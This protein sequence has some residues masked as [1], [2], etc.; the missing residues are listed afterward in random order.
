[1]AR[2]ID[3]VLVTDG[4]ALAKWQGGVVARLLASPSRRLVGWRHLGRG[5]QPG[6]RS[7]L[8]APMPGAELPAGLPAPEQLPSIE[9]APRAMS[10]RALVILDLTAAGLAPDAAGDADVWS[11]RFGEDQARDPLG[12]AIRDTARGAGATPVWL[13]AEGPQ[14]SRRILHQGTVPTGAGAPGRLVDGMLHEAIGWPALVDRSPV[15]KAEASAPE[16][17]PAPRTPPTGLLDR[18]PTAVLRASIGVRRLLAARDRLTRHDDWAIGLVDEPIDAFLEP[19]PTRSVRWLPRR[20]GTYAADPFGVV[21]D[22]SLHVFFEEFDQAHGQGRIAHLVV[23]SDGATSTPELVLDPGCHASYPFILEADGEVWMIPE[24]ADTGEVRL[25]RADPFPSRWILEA[26]LLQG[27]PVSDPTIVRHEDRWW[28]FGTSRGR[29]VDH[30]LRAWHAPELLGPWRGHALD[31]VKIDVRSARPAGTPFVVEG[32]LHRP[33]QD[34]SRR[35][36]GRLVINRID[37]LTPDAFAERP[38]AVVDPIDHDHPDGIH[39]L[40]SAGA[41]TLVDGN[42]VRFIPLTLRHELRA[43]LLGGAR[44]D[45][46]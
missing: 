21:R 12:V 28:L 35:Y 40:A 7:G 20:P 16:R 13:V 32:R 9:G 11:L 8:L 2:R 29:G 3:V 41:R 44:G 19:G 26:R 6:N 4:P 27:M 46:P 22:G 30:A 43:R 38:V 39:T 45:G 36:G 15:P 25:Y 10:G 24:T 33:G 17:P 34:S 1:M 5:V 18:L 42:A 23:G 31:P 37:R 14:G